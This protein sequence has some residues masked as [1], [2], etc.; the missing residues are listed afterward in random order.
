MYHVAG[1]CLT[2]SLLY[3]LSFSFYKAGFYSLVFH[4]KVWNIFLALTFLFTALAGVFMALQINYQW[5]VPFLKSLLKWHVEIGAAATIIGIF[6]FI[7]HFSYYGKIFSSSGNVLHETGNLS[8][9]QVSIN[10]NL[11]IVGFVSTSI[12]ILF[13]REIMNIAGGY[14]L[15]SGVF[16]GSWLIAS[17]S[18]A[19]IARKSGLNDQAKI[20][21]IFASAPFVS[22]LLLILFSRFFLQPGETPSFLTSMIFT[23]IVLLP[24]CLVSGFSFIKLT[25]AA[26][27]ASG[28][29]P[30]RSFSVE[31]TGSAISGMILSVITSGLFS[32]YKIFLTIAL[33]SLAYSLLTYYIMSRRNK[34]IARIIFAVILSFVVLTDPDIFFRQLLL[35][36]VKVMSTKDTPYGNVTRGEYAGEPAYFYNQ[37]LIAYHDDAA[38]REEDI[39]YA[40]LQRPYPEKILMISGNLQS[41]LSEITKYHIS[42]ITFIERDPE[43]IKRAITEI[44]NAPKLL[45]IEKGDAF[46]YL[47]APGEKMDAIIL[48]VPPPSTLSLDRYYITEFFNDAR[49]RLVKGGVFMCSPGPGDDYLNNESVEL[50]SSIYNSL[51][52]I[53]RHV[54]P[55]MGQKLYFIASDDDIS[56]S[57]C[58]LAE[59]RGI[60]NVYVGP[61]FLADDL[62]EAKSAQVASIMNKAVSPNRRDFPIAA[63]HFQEYNLSRTIHE[64]TPAIILMI[65]AFAVPGLAIR[66]RNITMYFSAA[67]LAGFEIIALFL[68]Q[69]TAGNMYQ[70]TGLILASLMAGLA[71][72][73]GTKLKF[74][75]PIPLKVK[76]LIL[77]LYYVLTAVSLG[78]ILHERGAASSIA[79][80]VCST[81]LPSFLTGHIYREMTIHDEA[82]SHP[83]AVYSADLAG[84]ALGFILISGAA[85]PV[86]GIRTSILLLTGLIFA[87]ILFGTNANK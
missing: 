71:A 87:G 61:D 16:L 29:A 30:G 51:S 63:F 62:V 85:I 77:A 69:L 55:V 73:S 20:S 44:S 1:T 50:Y 33:L 49:N 80:I 4:K 11:F 21:I 22:L 26:R 7:W 66:R 6:H 76:S 53:F 3:L 32:N 52:G 15:I 31:T 58:K 40:L 9:N 27:N 23:F 48:L 25:M 18:G 65:L 42:K 82:G 43:L 39:H 56:V 46:R 35:S 83:S 78:W 8:L 38:E 64:K 45:N 17:S 67:A 74:M 37:R 2:V 41:H 57:F 36:G 10:A 12:Q 28:A 19:A 34:T 14:E 81:L 70:L 68:I 79:I 47:R 75:D 72:G 5:N 60:K 86:L 84:S 24:F 54:K 59:E 13:M